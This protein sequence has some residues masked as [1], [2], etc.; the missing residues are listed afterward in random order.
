MKR[1]YKIVRYII[2]YWKLAVSNLVFNFLAVIFSLFS[3]T[4]AIPF[5]G[6]LFNNQSIIDQ[7]IPFE[8]NIESIQHNFN[9]FLSQI[10]TTKGPE[11]ALIFV[12]ILVVIMVLFKTLFMYSAEYFV[13]PLRNGVIKDIRNKIYNKVLKLHLGY[14]SEEKKG[15]II[16][17]MT[18]DVQEIEVS[19][20]RSLNIVFKEPIIIIVY[21]SSLLYMSLNLTLFVLLLLPVSGLII[22]RI[23]KGLRKRSRE[24]QKRMGIILSIIEETL[25]G[26]RIIKAFNSEEKAKRK[27]YRENGLYNKIMIKMWRRRDM[28]VPL[29]EFLGTMVVIFVMLYGGSL[30]LKNQGSLSSQ[31]FI[32]YLVIFSQMIN[33]VKAFS[34]AYYNIQKGLASAERVDAILD[35]QVTI[36]EI[37]KPENIKSFNQNIEYNNVYFKYLEEDVLKNINLNI[38]KGKTIAL[39]GQSGSGKSTLVDLLPRFYDTIKGEIK[40]DGIPVKNLKLYDL[41]GLMGI[42]NQESILFNDTIFNNIAFGVDNVSKE[43]VVKAAKIANAHNFIIETEHG[44]NTN[45]GDRGDKLSGGQ[46]Q[47]ISIARAVLKNPPIL[48][49]DEATSSLDTESER[50]VQDALTNLM[51]NRTSIVIAHRLSTVKYVD[52]IY[53]I[54]DGEIVENGKHEELLKLEGVYKKLHDL[55]M[56]A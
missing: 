14:F 1:F 16:A 31:A 53:V 3:F 29:S 46:R 19:V 56:F 44:Y 39:V 6:I 4:M 20:I 32:G 42:V 5:L 13:A 43:E 51:K 52:E 11:Q 21:L 9:Y 8:M 7:P 22:G 50:L 48:I 30:V 17:R 34:S 23:G 55:Q 18:S 15:D 10:I 40:I 41:R 24:G 25:T 35:A 54:H 49:L 36:K 26:L 33:P 12:S 37:E 38:P 45:I 47:R 28:A 27:F 2:P